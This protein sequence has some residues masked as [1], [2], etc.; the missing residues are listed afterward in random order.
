MKNF[1]IP[2][3]INVLYQN[4]SNTGKANYLKAGWINLSRI[5]EYNSYLHRYDKILP[6][7]FLS[8][9]GKRNYKYPKMSL[10]HAQLC[11]NIFLKEKSQ[12][13]WPYNSKK[14]VL[15]TSL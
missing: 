11:L 14:K 9:I 6:L 7:K 5:F 4:S 12:S 1:I 10:I 15:I 13:S 8:I 3:D 2:G